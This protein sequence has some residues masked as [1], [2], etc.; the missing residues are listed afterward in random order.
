MSTRFRAR[1]NVGKYRIVRKLASGPLADVYHAFDTVQ[2]MPVALKVPLLETERLDDVADFVSEVRIAS[3]LQHD[4]IL[5]VHNAAFIGKHFVIAMPLGRESLGSRLERRMANA[6]AMDLALQSLRALAHAHERKVIHCDIKPENFI[7]FPGQ[8]LCLADFGFAKVA[9]R[10]VKGS[11]SGTIDY[12]A[13]EQAMG[14]PRFAS[15][16]FSLG[17]VF[18]KMFAGVLPE[19]PFDWPS[20]GYE[21][22]VSRSNE[23]FAEVIREA[24]DPDPRRRFRDAGAMLEAVQASI[25]SARRPRG[26]PA[27]ESKPADG[28]QSRRSRWRAFKRDYGKQLELRANCRRCEGPVAMQM[29]AC[30]WCGTDNPAAGADQSMPAH[31]P[32]CERG[33]KLDW[34]YCA[35]CYGSGFEVETTRRFPD[36]RYV[37]KCANANCGQPLMAHMRYCPWCRSKVKRRW[38]L[39]E[40][41]KS[42]VTCKQPVAQKYWQFCAWCREP[43]KKMRRSTAKMRGQR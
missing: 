31:C 41:D 2:H 22:L 40:G 15:D 32:R 38:K 9:A 28:E 5:S 21:R 35:W 7:L 6:M 10:T 25:S 39:R 4:N 1:Q 43:V 34:N 36:K 26:K 24:I 19:Y 3:R 20:P 29:Q 8:H 37:A 27:A 16:V 18:H 42:C 17:L 11:G 23:A 30:P 14:K 13:P 33:V 12:I